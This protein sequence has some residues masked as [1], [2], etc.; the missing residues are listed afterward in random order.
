MNLAL[1]CGRPLGFLA[2]AGLI[3]AAGLWLGGCETTQKPGFRGIAEAG[4]ASVLVVVDETDERA[5]ASGIAGVKITAETRPP[6]APTRIL[7]TTTTDGTGKFS[8]D[9]TDNRALKDPIWITAEKDGFL[10]LREQIYLQ[11]GGRV[12][13]VVLAKSGK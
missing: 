5:K 7:A 1:A 13:V 12:L 2:A 6:N 4:P 3:G 8:I 11:A 10:K 9:I